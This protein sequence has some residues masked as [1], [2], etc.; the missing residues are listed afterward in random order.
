MFGAT[1]KAQKVIK[2]HKKSTVTELQFSDSHCTFVCVFSAIAL[3]EAQKVIKAHQKLTVTELQFTLFIHI[4]QFVCVFSA[5]AEAEKEVIKA[6]LISTF[7][8]PVPQVNTDCI[9]VM[10]VSVLCSPLYIRL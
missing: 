2:T 6:R 8:E 9:V 1:A 3:A 5:I 10:I 4:V 7:R